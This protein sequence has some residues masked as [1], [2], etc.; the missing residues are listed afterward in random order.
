[1]AEV[2]S[3]GK[4]Q[5]KSFMQDENQPKKL[6]AGL[7]IVATP[8]GNLGDISKRALETLKAVDVIAC[9]D[10]RVT[11]KLLQAYLIKKPTMPY[12][13]HNGES[14]RPK[15][16]RLIEEG[17]A[18][19]LVSDAGTPLISDPGFK[20]V[21]YL[22][23]QGHF[24]TSLPGPSAAIAALTLAGL[25]T[26]R[27][28]FL[29]FSPS[30]SGARQNWF[31]AEKNERGSLIYYESARRLA[32]GLADA[33][34]M[35][36]NRR[37]AV[38]REISKKFEEVVRGDLETLVARYGE[39][40]A[41]KGEIVVVIEGNSAEAGEKTKLD[42]DQLLAK[43]LEYMSVKSAAAFVSEI[44]GI[45]KKDIYNKALEIS[46]TQEPT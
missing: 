36:G 42:A 27:F 8:I 30:K 32:A 15:I 2:G 31:E 24:V 6:K 35:L 11:S 17:K 22:A 39:S 3:S 19:A 26:D 7:H 45:R 46:K 23:E 25:P 38:C 37:A 14:Q 18:V 9:E 13:E 10:T 34:K 40:G 1:M 5:G 33:L 29:G 4:F 20:L 16:E 21:E 41:P 43:S 44:S 12:H 28:L